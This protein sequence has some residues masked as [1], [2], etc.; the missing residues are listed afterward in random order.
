MARKAWPVGLSPSAVTVEV[1]DAGLVELESEFSNRR[2]AIRR[3]QPRWRGTVSLPPVDDTIDDDFQR[4]QE[5]EYL[6]AHLSGN[7]DDWTEIPVERR[8]TTGTIRSAGADNTITLNELD[9]ALEHA[10]RVGDFQRIHDR[11]YVVAETKA[12]VDGRTPVVVTPNLD[13]E[14]VAGDDWSPGDVVSARIVGWDGGGSTLTPDWYNEVTLNWEEFVPGVNIGANQYPQ[15]LVSIEDQEVTVGSRISVLVGGVFHDPGGGTLT[16]EVFSASPGHVRATISGDLLTLEGIRSGES[17]IT[18]RAT[19]PG[20][21]WDET[22]FIC[23]CEPATGSVAP[24]VLRNFTRTVF[25]VGQLR[26]HVLSDFFRDTASYTESNPGAGLSYV[27]VS[28]DASIVR[29][30]ESAGN[31]EMVGEGVGDAV[32]TVRALGASGLAAEQQ[33]DVS[34]FADGTADPTT[35]SPRLI[36]GINDMVLNVNEERVVPLGSHFAPL[37]LDFNNPGAAIANSMPANVRVTVNGATMTVRGLA[38]LADQTKPAVVSVQGFQVATGLT[39]ER[40]SFN[41][42]VTATVNPTGECPVQ[43]AR[44]PDRTVQR[45]TPISIRLSRYFGHRAGTSGTVSYANPVSSVAARATVAIAD[46]VLTVTGNTNG[47]TN[48]TVTTNNPSPCEA[49][50]QTFTLTVQTAVA[51]PPPTPPTPTPPVARVLEAKF[52]PSQI[53]G[54]I[55]AAG[56]SPTFNLSRYLQVFD[57][58]TTTVDGETTTSRSRISSGFNATYS[59]SSNSR[60]A[61]SIAG[62][63]VTWPIPADAI[64][65]LRFITVQAVVTRTYTDQGE[66]NDQSVTVTALL[67]IRIQGAAEPPPGPTPTDRFGRSGNPAKQTVEA[68][69]PAF[70][71]N[72]DGLYDAV[73]E[74]LEFAVQSNSDPLV[75][76]A[77]AQG[78]GVLVTPGSKVGTTN[79][80]IQPTDS[81]GVTGPSV[82]LVVETTAVNPRWPTPE[83]QNRPSPQTVRA[84]QNISF[85]I[86]NVFDDTADLLSVTVLGTSR[87]RIQ[88]SIAGTTVT[89]RGVQAGS[90][91][92]QLWGQRSATT[93]RRASNSAIVS[94]QV[95]V[96]STGGGGGNGNGNGDNGI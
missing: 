96:T 1:W 68:Q 50:T 19:E 10:P 27:V 48:I 21:L 81:D 52:V 84:G 22:S 73:S 7:P 44:M 57:K 42:R 8:G 11:L 40:E 66:N 74:P 43:V 76:T 23:D 55:Q 56:T 13:P 38:A 31:L 59:I 17:A 29:V 91:I 12:V 32:I 80:V 79:I 34:C 65:V 61:A 24:S 20:G 95:T 30:S 62:S 26:S 93:E 49:V 63:I 14:V 25:R 60:V 69:S 6:M 87:N 39:T 15:Q 33:F 67:G 85:S 36:K 28:T 2:Q 54:G 77:A 82:T 18:L 35:E 4:R 86:A 83:I 72:L 9:S 90:A 53:G 51:P 41:V 3:S 64:S 78:Q 16:L 88:A 58:T 92:L 5:L 71:V 89:V 75:A 94:V 37:P 46:G 45:G 47:T 70:Q